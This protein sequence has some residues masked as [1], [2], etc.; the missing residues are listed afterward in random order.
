MYEK[1]ADFEFEVCETMYF[2]DLYILYIDE[3]INLT[4]IQSS[5]NFER[6]YGI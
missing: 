6:Y 1:N 3:Y 2:H 5:L 4:D